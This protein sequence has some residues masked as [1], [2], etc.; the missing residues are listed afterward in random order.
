[1]LRSEMFKIAYHNNA[2]VLG[3]PELEQREVRC[4]GEVQDLFSL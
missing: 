3:T 2:L 4:H 1:M